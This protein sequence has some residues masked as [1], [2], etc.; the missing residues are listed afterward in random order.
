MKDNLSDIIIEHTN[1]YPK[2]RPC[3]AVKLVYQ[4]E[5]GNGHMVSDE[6]SSLNRL[7]K[8]VSN[9]ELNAYGKLFEDIGNGYCRLNLA[10]LNTNEVPLERINKIFINSAGTDGTIHSFKE[11]L[12]L[13]HEFAKTGR[14][15]FTID[16]F[17]DYI[18]SFTVE[19]GAPSHSPEYRAAYSPAYRV[20]SAVYAQLFD[21]IKAIEQ[22]PKNRISAMALEG[23]SASGKTTAAR[24]LGELYRA[25]IVHIDDF[26]MPAAA[27]VTPEW[28]MPGGNINYARFNAQIAQKINYCKEIVY[29]PYNCA[30]DTLDDKVVQPVSDLII[31]EGA[32][33]THPFIKIDYAVK[34]F[35]DVDANE[36]RIRILNREGKEGAAEYFENWLPREAE[37]F[38]N[39]GVSDNCDI[40]VHI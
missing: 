31:I 4:N 30:T 33:S 35:F 24:L 37:Y 25:P 17:E 26:Y 6:I 15:S 38:K 10:V 40:H 9:V 1:R 8:E 21:I 18:K 28:Q 20:I 23:H 7:T 13:V 16:E 12:K 19:G 5:F 29:N 39:Y 34:A 3:D 32:Y 36:Q 2:M 14:F 27:R 11:K 22:L